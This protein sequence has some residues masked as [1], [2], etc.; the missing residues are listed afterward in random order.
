[1]KLNHSTWLEIFQTSVL[2]HSTI[3]KQLCSIAYRSSSRARPSVLPALR[4]LRSVNQ[5][6]VFLL[7]TVWSQLLL[8]RLHQL[9]GFASIAEE[10][11]NCGIEQLGFCFRVLHI[12]HCRSAVLCAA[13]AALFLQSSSGLRL[14]SML[15]NRPRYMD[16]FLFPSIACSSLIEEGSSNRFLITFAFAVQLQASIFTFFVEVMNNL[17]CFIRSVYQNDDAIGDDDEQFFLL[18]AEC[19]SKPRCHR[20]ILSA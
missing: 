8:K 20:R 16:S 6:S 2:F 1:M 17:F 13:Q 11:H 18:L 15:F 14:L 7:I 5:L 12:S 9:P 4:R 19:V 10:W 3:L